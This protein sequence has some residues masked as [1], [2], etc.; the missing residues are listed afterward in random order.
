MNF[1]LLQDLHNRMNLG[2]SFRL[3]SCVDGCC[4]K[5][6]M[7]LKA[8]LSDFC[9]LLTNYVR[10]RLVNLWRL[11]WASSVLCWVSMYGDGSSIMI[12]WL[13]AKLFSLK[14][15][16]LL[17]REILSQTTSIVFSFS[18]SSCAVFPCTCLQN[19]PTHH[20]FCF[21]MIF[22]SFSLADHSTHPLLV[23]AVFFE[24]HSNNVDFRIFV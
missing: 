21:L 9:T 15:F 4:C 17:G 6:P 23:N 20:L 12:R 7:S 19:Q 18:Q 24:L 22:C 8:L 13:Q 2:C 11:C 3:A 1:N 16:T 14:S 10:W 5:G